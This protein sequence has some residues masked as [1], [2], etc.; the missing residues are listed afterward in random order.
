MISTLEIVKY[1]HY[2]LRTQCW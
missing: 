1:D 2:S